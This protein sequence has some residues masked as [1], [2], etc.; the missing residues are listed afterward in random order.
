MFQNS[1]FNN[2]LKSVNWR[3]DMKAMSKQSSDINEPIA[4]FEINLSNKKTANFDL[5]REEI[6]AMIDKLNEI[7]TNYDNLINTQN[8]QK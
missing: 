2:S 1:A 8:T 5:N 6:S 4:S 3:V 7:Q